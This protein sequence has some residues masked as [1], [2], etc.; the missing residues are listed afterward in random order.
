MAEKE[1]SK[2][3]VKKVTYKC[4]DKAA[5]TTANKVSSIDDTST[6]E[7]YPSAKA[8]YSYVQPQIGKLDELQTEAKSNLVAAINEAA[9]K[10]GDVT[11]PD[12]NQN[13][14]TA[15]DYIKNRP[16]GGIMTHC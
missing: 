8:V 14:E 10:G 3:S 15:S 6:D 13:D 4:T 9:T 7:Q 16:G 11:T 1:I 5:E 12:W 2:I